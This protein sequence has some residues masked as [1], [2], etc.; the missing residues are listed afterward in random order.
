MVSKKRNEYNGMYIALAG[1]GTMA[2]GY[3]ALGWLKNNYLAGLSVHDDDDYGEEE[4]ESGER[5]VGWKGLGDLD[6]I[7]RARMGDDRGGGSQE[8]RGGGFEHG[9]RQSLLRRDS[10][11]DGR[12]E[13]ESG[14][15][16]ISRIHEGGGLDI[17]E[18][19]NKGLNVDGISHAPSSHE[20]AMA[21]RGTSTSGSRLRGPDDEDASTLEFASAR[22][23]PPTR[24]GDRGSHGGTPTALHYPF[25][26]R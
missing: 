11:E 8:D 24:D 6:R 15:F 17:S 9:S 13:H 1:V 25:H 14:G 10:G 19:G 18:R 23:S 2:A 26:S 22:S 21:A 20:M 7:E 12:F 16:G 5:R 3:Y 4:G